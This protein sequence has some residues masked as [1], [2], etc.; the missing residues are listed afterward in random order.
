MFGRGASDERDMTS[1]QFIA[2][3]KP[4]RAEG[5][6]RALQSAYRDGCDLPRELWAYIDR[7]DRIRL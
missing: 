6:A 1:G 7:L 2:V 4:S 3:A 5:I